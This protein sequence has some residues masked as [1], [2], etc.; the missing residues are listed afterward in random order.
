MTRAPN[1]YVQT[2]AVARTA[3]SR[4]DRQ[5]E[6]QHNAGLPMRTVYLHVGQPKTG[7][8]YLQ[9][10]FLN[11]ADQLKAH[12]IVYPMPRNPSHGKNYGVNSGNMR[13]HQIMRN[14]DKLARRHPDHDLL[15]S[16]EFLYR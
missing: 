10:V 13:T 5:G 9:S 14:F 8:S 11:G 16:S 4:H 7:T 2:L 1:L 15:F 3:K 6:K 12:G